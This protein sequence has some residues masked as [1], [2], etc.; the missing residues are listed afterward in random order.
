MEVRPAL[1]LDDYFRTF[2]GLSRDRR[3]SMPVKGLPHPRLQ[4]ALVMERHT[5]PEIAAP[6]IPL[7]RCNGSA[8][9]CSAGSARRRG[10]AASFPVRR[11]LMARSGQVIRNPATG[12]TVTFLAVS[13]WTPT[14]SSCSSR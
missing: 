6:R 14:G 3:I 12:E 10:I 8:G 11:A 13:S 7:S 9:A 4:V 2:L 5:A 1:H